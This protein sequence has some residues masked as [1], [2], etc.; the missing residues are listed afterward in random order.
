[1]LAGMSISQIASPLSVLSLN[2][3]YGRQPGLG[4][5]FAAINAEEKYDFLMLQEAN[6][7]VT[8]MLS[9]KN[10][11]KTLEFSYGSHKDKRGGVTIVHRAS[12]TPEAAEYL[13]LRQ[14]LIPSVS[15]HYGV[16]VANFSL[17]QGAITIASLHLHAGL[18]SDLRRREV[19]FIKD[20]LQK[21]SAE[22]GGSTIIGG[23]FNSGYPWERRRLDDIFG[24]FLVNVT[25]GIGATL[26]SLY[27]EPALNIVNDI[28]W[29]LSR[30]GI[31][32]TA[33]VDHIYVDRSLAQKQ[34]QSRKLLDRVSDH[35]PIEVTIAA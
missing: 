9:C 2:C 33:K 22:I 4:D 17:P 7:E 32:A 28:S 26:D 6:S 14:F 10:A 24:S 8:D 1:M 30:F 15:S 29:L 13:P 5:F 27:A 25:T 31:H 21:R 20:F 11:Y 23:D 18:R 19:N 12:Y 3:Q 35:S 16:A 34:L